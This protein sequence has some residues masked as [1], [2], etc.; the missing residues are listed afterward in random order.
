M[1]VSL[2]IENDQLTRSL[3]MNSKELQSRLQDEMFRRQLT[4]YLE[5][6]VKLDFEWAREPSESTIYGQ[7]KSS[8]TGYS[9]PS[10][11]TSMNGSDRSEVIIT[12]YSQSV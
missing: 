8:Y 2:I 9:F 1:F 12:E 7:D 11:H 4:E 6:I 3:E 5:S 10:Y